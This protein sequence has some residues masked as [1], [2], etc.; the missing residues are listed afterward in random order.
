MIAR[1]QVAANLLLLLLALSPL[2]AAVGQEN[3]RSPKP[4]PPIESLGEVT[5]DR[6][7]FEWPDN[8]NAA[9]KIGNPEVVRLLSD[10]FPVVPENDRPS[11]T[12]HDQE[13]DSF[14]FATFD[15]GP[16]FLVAATDIARS[17]WIREA[18]LVRCYGLT[19]SY[20]VI[21]SDEVTSSDLRDQILDLKKDGTHQILVTEALWLG[22]ARGYGGRSAYIFGVSKNRVEDESS[23]FPEFYR[24]KILPELDKEARELAP[25]EGFSNDEIE[26]VRAGYLYTKRE[27][28]RRVLGDRTAGLID[29]QKWEQSSNEGV[30]L[31][32]I[33]TYQEIDSPEADAGLIRLSLSKSKLTSQWARDAIATK[34]DMIA[35]PKYYER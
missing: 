1:F 26:V 31:Y 18:T 7:P 30:R 28:E 13:V 23:E 19:C 29:A 27:M 12:S 33:Y 16:P 3:R 11:Y 22:G 20:A 15:D 21:H 5:L 9:S 6:T 8:A 25:N 2:L 24:T 4:R 17:T 14:T 34:Q 32:A 10:I 35:N